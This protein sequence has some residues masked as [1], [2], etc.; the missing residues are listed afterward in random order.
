V[1]NGSVSTGRGT[2]RIVGNVHDLCV[3]AQ[4]GAV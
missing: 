3:D 2:Q 1:R 4:V